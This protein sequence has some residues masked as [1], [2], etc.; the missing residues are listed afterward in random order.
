LIGRRSL[1]G[2]AAVVLLASRVHS[3]PAAKAE[4]AK[5]C[6][7]Q[8]VLGPLQ[9]LEVVTGK[10]RAKFLVEMADNDHER[11]RGMMCRTAMAADRG[12]LFDFKIERDVQFWMHNTLIPL[13]MVFIQGDGRVLSIVSNAR[14]KDD[15]AQPASG[16]IHVRAVL[17]IPGGRAA[18]I[19]LLPGDRVL[20]RIFPGG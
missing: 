14:P 12:M 13:D 16:P 10:G 11:E 20:H 4:G 9:P 8:P 1:I 17:E 7:P 19:G 2:L 6:V 3:E 18:Q 5:A 15:T